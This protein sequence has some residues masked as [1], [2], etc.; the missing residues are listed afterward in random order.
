M[1]K[2][3]LSPVFLYVRLIHSLVIAGVILKHSDDSYSNWNITLDAEVVY[4]GSSLGCCQRAYIPN[5]A[6]SH[7]CFGG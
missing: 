7:D 1:L 2:I 5:T 4:S 3:I 6:E